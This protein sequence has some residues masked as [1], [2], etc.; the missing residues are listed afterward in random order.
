MGR[1]LLLCGLACLCVHDLW[2][3]VELCCTYHD[4]PLTAYIP[5]FACRLHTFVCSRRAF[6]FYKGCAHK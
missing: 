1:L 3:S 5:L 2:L 4:G 6:R